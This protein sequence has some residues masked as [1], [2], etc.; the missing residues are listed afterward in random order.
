M[1]STL[2][3]FIRG[4]YATKKFIPLHEPIFSGKEREYVLDTIDSTFVSSIGEYVNEFEQSVE[5]YTGIKYAIATVNGTAALHSILTLLNISRNDLVITQSLTFVATINS[6]IYTGATPVFLDV[7][8]DT[9]S[10]SPTSLRDYLSQNCEVRNDNYCWDIQENKIIKAC[11]LMHTLGFPA[12][13]NEIKRLCDE[14]NIILLEDAAESLG[15][16]YEGKHTGSFGTLSAL[17][18]NGNKVITTG[19]GGMILTNNENLYNQAKHM[20]TTAKTS[21]GWSWEHDRVGYNYRMPNIN[22]ALGLGQIEL[23][24]R[25]ITSKRSLAE[26]YKEHLR[27]SDI[28]FI[29]ERENT[30]ANFWLN[31]VLMNSKEERDILLEETNT[32]GI[33][34]RPLWRPIDELNLSQSNKPFELVNTK[35]LYDRV[36]SLPSTPILE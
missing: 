32:A 30:K 3:E 11:L 10:L 34:T 15:S 23:I 9:M 14:Y 33:G 6:I 29:D 31:S 22:A 8:R 21:K 27:N 26:S 36:I 5:S 1:F 18:F 19:G 17:S 13:L 2:I 20:T 35:W 28:Q 25:K 7:E 4:L 12:E 24:D 16:Y